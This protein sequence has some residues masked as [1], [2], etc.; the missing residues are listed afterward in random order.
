MLFIIFLYERE[1]SVPK[2][3]TN[4]QMNNSAIKA[5]NYVSF[6]G[7]IPSLDFHISVFNRQLRIAFATLNARG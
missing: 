5:V 7:K 2:K 4:L 1:L 3:I 6:D